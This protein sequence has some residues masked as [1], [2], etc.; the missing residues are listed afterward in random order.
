MIVFIIESTFET[1]NEKYLAVNSV[2]S[3]LYKAQQALQEITKEEKTKDATARILET[4]KQIIIT[5]KGIQ[6]VYNII[7]QQVL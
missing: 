3:S 1:K 6:K 2:F 5:T 7:R 4:E